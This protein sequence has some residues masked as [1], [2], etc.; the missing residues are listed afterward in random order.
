M[1]K[2]DLIKNWTRDLRKNGFDNSTDW[3]YIIREVRKAAEIKVGRKPKK[4]PEFLTMDEVRDI[5]SV[6]YNLQHSRNTTK[7]GLIIE[8]LLKSGLRNSELCNLRVENIDFKTG[9][10]KVV[11]GKG[12]K[13]RFALMP[14]SLLNKLKIYLSGRES[15]YLFLN[16]HSK[17]FST[18][19]LQYIVKEIREKAAIN[20]QITPHTLRHTFASVLINEGIDIRKIQRLLGHEDISTTQLYTHVLLND[21]KDEVLQITDKIN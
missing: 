6:S 2:Q 10:F 16:E 17:P 7:K 18:R 15:G 8:T 3:K 1:E 11:E 12:K 5:L 9:V 13:D 14:V 20:K 19:T 4:L 21:M